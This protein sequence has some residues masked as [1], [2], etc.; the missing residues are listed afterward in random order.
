MHSLRNVL[1]MT[2]FGVAIGIAVLSPSAQ[3]TTTSRILVVTG[4]HD[5]DVTAFNTMWTSFGATYTVRA[6]PVGH[7][8]FDNITGWN[9]DILVFYNHQ[10]PGNSLTARH[11]ENFQAL[12][13][14]GVGMFVLHHSVAAYPHF[15]EFEAMAGGK[16]RS[17][18]YYTDNLSTY[19]IPVNINVLPAKTGH[20]LAQGIAASFTVNDE[21][22]FKMTFAADNDVVFKTDYVDA[23]GPIA[24]SRKAGNSRVFTTILGNGSG[25]FSNANFRRMVKNGLDHVL[26]CSNGDNREVCKPV[27]SIATPKAPSLG[28]ARFAPSHQV[29][30]SYGRDLDQASYRLDG[31][32]RASLIP[33]APTP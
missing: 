8:V 5:Y 17:A 16:Y 28:V 11:K 12:L 24:W 1:G 9:H 33:L 26:P 3:L 19:K 25:I 14:Q 22:Y 32:Q 15:P 7:E 31:R 6:L 30:F 13:N 29:G 2:L 20:P 10:N 4:G 27:V 23:D 21:M 18:A